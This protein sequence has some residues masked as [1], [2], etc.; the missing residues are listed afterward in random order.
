MEKGEGEGEEGMRRGAKE[1][2]EKNGKDMEGKGRWKEAA[3]R[4]KGMTWEKSEQRK[5]KRSCKTGKEKDR[6]RR[7]EGMWREKVQKMEG[8][9][10]EKGK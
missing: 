4:D 6:R 3:K 1:S 10:N 7:K 8:D 5:R 9:G 2:Q